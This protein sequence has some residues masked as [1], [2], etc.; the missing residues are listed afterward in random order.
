LQRNERVVIKGIGKF[1]KIIYVPVAALGVSNININAFEKL[2]NAELNQFVKK[3]QW[4]KSSLLS[5]KQGDEIGLFK[6]GST[7]VMIVEVPRNFKF[8]EIVGQ[9]VR[10]GDVL[11]SVVAI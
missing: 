3:D 4:S 5:I 11:G 6:M 10:F 1:G 9:H 2:W 8:K 7:V